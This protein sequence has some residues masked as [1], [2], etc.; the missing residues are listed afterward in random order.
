MGH[1][2]VHIRVPILGEVTL[3]TLE[4]IVVE[5]QAIDI[6]MGGIRIANPSLSIWDNEY[7]IRI[8]LAGRGTIEFRAVLIHENSEVAGFKIVDIDSENLHLIFL[9]IADFQSTEDFIKHIEKGNILRDW[10][11]DDHGQQLDVTF[12]VV[13]K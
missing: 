7:D 12:E 11:V 8:T 10:F 5:A 1:K 4:G 9:V 13:A 2:R 3:S 6:S